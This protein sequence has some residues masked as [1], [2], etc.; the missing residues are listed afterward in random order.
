MREREREQGEE[1]GRG[2]RKENGEEQ[3]EG[4]KTRRGKEK[5][6]ETRR[7]GRK[8]SFVRARGTSWYTRKHLKSALFGR[9]EPRCAH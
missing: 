7:G 6:K 2:K 8:K 4:T 3:M 5:K 1:R 9:F